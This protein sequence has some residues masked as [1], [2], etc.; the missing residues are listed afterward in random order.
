MTQA[1]ASAFG[2]LDVWLARAGRHEQ[3]WEK[4]GAHLV[5]TGVRFAVWAPNARR[6]SVVGDF[7]DWDA[8][9]DAL[10]PVDET[11]IWEGVVDRAAAGQ[12][13]KFVRRRAREGR[14]GGV[15]G[16]RP[17]AD[18][19]GGLRARVRV[20]RRGVDGGAPGR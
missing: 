16:R 11:G 20:E 3:L 8:G 15:P 10:V 19:V 9:A 5:E 1:R 4:L 2:E 14:S 7:N 18:G 17:A 12:R 13:Y 6:V